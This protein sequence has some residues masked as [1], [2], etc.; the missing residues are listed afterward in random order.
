MPQSRRDFIKKTAITTAGVYMGA[1]A[2]SAKSY[3][4]NMG[5]ND[6]VRVGVVGFSDRH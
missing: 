1:S 4:N 5:A 2:F 6:R 3:R